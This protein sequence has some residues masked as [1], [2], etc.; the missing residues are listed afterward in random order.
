MEFFRFKNDIPFMRH[1][2]VFNVIS[3]ITF[4]AAI[5][6]L[7]TRGLNFGVDFRGGTVIE[8]QYAHAADFDRVRT[9]IDAEARRILGAALRQRR[10]RAGAAAAQGRRIERQAVRPGDGRA[11]GR[12]RVGVAEARRVR[13]PAGGQGAL[14]ERRAG[15]SAG[16]DRHRRVPGDALRVA[17]RAG[18]DH[19]QHARRRDHSRLLRVLPVGIFAARAGGGAGGARLF[20]Q[21]IG[22]HRRPDPREFPQDAQGD[23]NARDR[24]RDHAHDVAHDHHARLDA[25]HGDVDADLRRR[26]AALLRAGA[27]DRHP[28]RHLLV[29]A[30]AG[31]AG[32]VDGR[33]ARRPCQG[34]QETRHRRGEDPAVA[35][36]GIG[37]AG[38]PNPAVLTTL[39][40][41]FLALDQSIAQLAAHY[42]AW[43]YAILAAVIF[44]ETGLVVFPVLPGDSVLFLA[45]A[46]IASAGL[47]VHLLVLVLTIAAV[48][49]VGLNYAVG[50]YVGPKVFERPDSRWLRREHLLRTQRFYIRYGGV[51]I[52][53]ARFVP[54]IRTFAPFLAGVAGMRYA[55][56]LAYNV[57]GGLLWIAMLTYAGYFFGNIPWVKQNLTLILAAIVVA[58]LLP[59][60]ATF[61]RE[62][63]QAR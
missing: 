44:A 35:Q 43:F 33:V 61:V 25:D 55:R 60:I 63:K 59:A 23:G 20:G 4:L 46:V 9:A 14:R 50:R 13:R 42:G 15:A 10:D 32:D 47:N 56:F 22:R 21:R 62:R 31:A 36:G 29:G 5:F 57:I 49:G 48:A 3:M 6:F 17:L 1:A 11:Q 16:G 8:V 12:R 52:I 40:Y 18:G 28:V 19:R 58:S 34:R 2:L 24:Q 37:K 30:G 27:F 45:G 53:L 41:S 26:D 7:S 51:T 39:L 54:I 38:R